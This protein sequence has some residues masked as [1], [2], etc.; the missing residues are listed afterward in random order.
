MP[1]YSCAL[2]CSSYHGPSRSPAG[3]PAAAS[4]AATNEPYMVS[5]SSS[6]GT[7]AS[8]ASSSRA[9]VLL[10]APGG[11]ATTHASAV[12]SHP[13]G[14]RVEVR[15]LGR[16]APGS[17][18]REPAA[19]GGGVRPDPDQAHHPAAELGDPGPPPA[20]V[21]DLPGER[22]RQ[23][24]RAAVRADLARGGRHAR[25]LVRLDMLVVPRA[26]ALAGR[27]VGRRERRRD[28]RTVHGVLV[29]QRRHRCERR[30]QQPRDRALACP[31]RPGHHPRDRDVLVHVH[32]LTRPGRPY[33]FWTLTAVP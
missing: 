32:T 27:T 19:Q 25:V 4:V 33:F 7:G 26:L 29:E 5:L 22:P 15:Q 16:V 11:P 1:A 10:P 3:R 31:R 24:D 28:E 8:D 30:Q 2:T 20:G 23:Q 9:T 17:P 12:K 21:V 14:E 6:A 18:G 13:R